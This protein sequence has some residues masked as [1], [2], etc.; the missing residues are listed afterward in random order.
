VLLATAPL[1]VVLRTRVYART[2]R[3]LLTLACV[4]PPFVAWDYLA[5]GAGHWTF[6][7]SRTLGPTI[8]DLPVEELLFF[9]VVPVASVIT[10]EAVR[11]L[12]GW[13]VGGRGDR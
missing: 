11:R 12:S 8:G 1:E 7:L 4:A 5:T 10:L 2:R 6:D 3:L 9:L 13:S